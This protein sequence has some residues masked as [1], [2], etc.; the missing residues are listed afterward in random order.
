MEG[1]T[2]LFRMNLNM[3]EVFSVFSHPEGLWA[4]FHLAGSPF[5]E[6]F[7]QDWRTQ[8][9]ELGWEWDDHQYVPGGHD[10]FQLVAYGFE[11]VV[12]LLLNPPFADAMRL[13][14]LRLMRRGPTYYG[15]FHGLDL[16]DA[17]FSA[18]DERFNDELA[19]YNGRIA[20]L[21][22]EAPGNAP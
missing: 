2:L 14:N 5:E 16:I 13:M 10:Q 15:K 12:Q 7:G 1:S 8:L 19:A 9:T 4:T 18:F 3:Q 6:S 21:D 17:A 22:Q 11:E 20:A